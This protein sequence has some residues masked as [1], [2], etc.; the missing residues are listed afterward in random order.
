MSKDKHTKLP[1]T[2]S[3]V[4]WE[5][6]EKPDIPDLILHP[7]GSH[8]S[9]AKGIALIYRDDDTDGANAKFILFAVN[10]YPALLSACEEALEF[11]SSRNERSC[12]LEAKLVSAINA[13]KPKGKE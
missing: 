5:G 10:S 13:A 8:H 1:W 11:L 4:S 7:K 2:V 9:L 3:E 12:M 6:Q